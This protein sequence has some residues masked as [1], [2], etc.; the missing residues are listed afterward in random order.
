MQFNRVQRNFLAMI[1]ALTLALLFSGLLFGKVTKSI[2]KEEPDELVIQLRISARTESDLF[3]TRMMVGLPSA[4]IPITN[5]QFEQK[6]QIPFQTEIVKKNK[7]FAWSQQ[8]R[9]QNLET[10]ILTIYPLDNTGDYFQMITIRLKF[11]TPGNTYRQS[12]RTETMLL[13]NRV[14][15]W[16]TAKKWIHKDPRK[17]QRTFDLPPG[18][19]ISFQLLEDGI[20]SI[21]AV[22]LSTIISNLNELDPR[23]LQLYMS[24]ELGRSR[25]QEPNQVIPDNLIEVAIQIIGEEDGLLDGDDKIIFYGR[26]P[27]GFDIE[28]QE[29]N[30][31]QNLY[32]NSNKAWLL[33]PDDSSLRGRRTATDEPPETVDL[34]LDYGNAS[35]HSE[36]DLVNLAA[37][38]TLWLGNAVSAGGSQAVIASLPFPKAGVDIEIKA[39]LKGH[40]LSE[41]TIASH[42]ISLHHMNVSGNQIGNT[43]IWSG[44]G[45]RTI[46]DP[47][48]DIT[49][50]NGTNYFHF[51]NSST[52]GNSAPYLDYFELQYGRELTFD[53]G[54]EFSSPVLGQN[55]RFIF[56][57]TASA[58]HSLWD[59]S[60]PSL[61][62]NITISPDGYA[63]WAAT[64]DGLGRFVFFDSENLPE[65]T[66][67]VLESTSQFTNLRNTVTQAGYIII[68]PTEFEPAA[69]PL[70]EL[71]SPAVYAGLETVY[72]EFSAGNPDPMAIRTFIQWTQENWQAPAPFAALL[73]GDGGYDYRNI[74][75]HS[76]IVVPTIQVPGTRSYAS[77]DRLAAL[78]GNLPEIALGRFPARNSNEVDDFVEKIVALET[79]P[80]FGPWRQTVTLIADDAARPEPSHG[81]VSTGKSHT[82]NSEEL[83]AMIP[84]SIYTDKL[85]MMEFPEVSDAS[86]YGV[87]KPDATQALF[88]R[89]NAGTA[90]VSYIGHGSPYQ[91]AQERL[92][93]LDRGDINS[94]N[95]GLRLPL[96]IVGTCSFGHFDDPLTESFAEELIRQPLNAASMIIS[97]TRA[98]TVT[99]NERYTQDLFQ[100]MFANNSVSPAPAGVILQTIKDGTSES[101]YFHL[102][103]DPAMS[104]PMPSAS[105]SLSSIVPD[106]LRTLATASFSGQQELTTGSG[107][108]FISVLDAA[109]S[110]TR[111]YTINSE[112]ESLSYTLPGATLF[113]GQ[114]TFQGT[115][116]SGQVRIPQDISYSGDPARLMVYLH[117]NQ[118]DAAGVLEQIPLVGGGITADEIGPII[119]FETSSGLVLR[120]GDHFSME[121]TLIIRLS[122]PIGINVTNETGHEIQ[123]TDLNS[124]LSE[125]ITRQF[126]YD[127]NSITTGTI[128]VFSLNDAANLHLLVKA[129]DN[130]NNPNEQ[131]I[132]LSRIFESKLKIYNA[133][134]YPNPFS[135]MTQFAFEITSS[136]EVEL[137]IYSLGGRRIKSFDPITLQPGYHYI[138]WDGND[139]FG[140][141]LANGVYLYRLK[142]KGAKN[143]ETYIGRCAKFQ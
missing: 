66:E 130:A 1:R 48:A 107:Y 102:F 33:I 12:S 8:Q 113:R 69:Q 68:G 2:L 64:P 46:S 42:A 123:V 106:T 41:T 97:T 15:N 119:N 26:G 105:A 99:G 132:K 52:D 50:V 129:W 96:W 6:S 67:L 92:L 85:Y 55:V 19:W 137:D 74:T 78:Y 70:R 11:D 37:S 87:I 60:N 142:A 43:T 89:L 101:E 95:T 7:S 3:P 27:S 58:G 104:L 143:T 140:G 120:S 71:R 35:L 38:G 73:L 5:I 63:E 30:W 62:E 47:S 45:T 94:M 4:D 114:F 108:G 103:G 31:H 22:E 121:E 75:G 139:A 131:E 77:D 98:I 116:F 10:A 16:T 56:S 18:Q 51:V 53:G 59:I 14:M 134:N 115:E 40:S 25:T 122:D 109:R 126:Y 65:V 57:G 138:D 20:T 81:S 91:L 9:I 125:T 28:G 135:N 100:T 84:S 36:T 112:P 13:E 21:S 24:S 93:Y 29:I 79:N 49:P 82:L 141:Q 117:D 54:F 80:E 44:T 127:Q 136:A 83:A 34:A 110:V 124:G 76:T 88:D 17:I 61:P 133:Y 72:D 39:T 23:S 128:D 90:I 86:A 118:Q 111:D 32:F